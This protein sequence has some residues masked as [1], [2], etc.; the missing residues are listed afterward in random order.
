MW[1]YLT[2]EQKLIATAKNISLPLL[3][4]ILIQCEWRSHC[5]TF[6]LDRVYTL[7]FHQC[8]M[9][10]WIQQKSIWWVLPSDTSQS[11][12]SR[13]CINPSYKSVTDVINSPM[14]ASP[15]R[16]RFQPYRCR[17]RT[18][19][20][21]FRFYMQVTALTSSCCVG[22]NSEE[23]CEPVGGGRGGCVVLMPRLRGWRVLKPG[24]RRLCWRPPAVSP[25]GA[26]ASVCLQ[27]LTLHPI[28]TPAAAAARQPHR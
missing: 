13:L 15:P 3:H 23:D 22:K 14:H 16:H 26:P 7:Q 5:T 17:H 27:N 12:L 18:V 10:I 2:L 20:G 11:S 1:R 6:T 24:A 28:I 25:T 8:M 19:L 4:F 21:L 9:K